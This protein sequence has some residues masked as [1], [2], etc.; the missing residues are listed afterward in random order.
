MMSDRG[1]IYIYIYIFES[2]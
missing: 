1:D 2:F